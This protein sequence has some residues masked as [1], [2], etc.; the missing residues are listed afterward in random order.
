MCACAEVGGAQVAVGSEAVPVAAVEKAAS[1]QAEEY[2][3]VADSAEGD[4]SNEELRPLHGEWPTRALPE[5]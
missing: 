4:G 1:V 3:T 5:C 2:G